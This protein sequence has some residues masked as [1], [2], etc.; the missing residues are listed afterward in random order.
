M[1]LRGSA[2]TDYR[3]D[4]AF[5]PEG[6]WAEVVGTEPVAPGPLY[7]FPFFA[8]LALGVCSV[9]LGL[10]RRALEELVALAAEKRYAMSSRSLAERPTVQAEVADA[11]AR[12]RSARALMR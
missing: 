8:A 9:A 10:A 5:V 2:S 4:D 11:E 3:V 7:R 6:R 1:G 12:Y